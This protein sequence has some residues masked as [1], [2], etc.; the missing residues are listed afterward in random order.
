MSLMK[1][2]CTIAC[3]ELAKNSK[4][5][6]S[7]LHFSSQE[8]VLS[9]IQRFGRT[10][11]FFGHS[12]GRRTTF[13]SH[14]CFLAAFET[15]APLYPPSA[16][17]AFRRGNLSIISLKTYSASSLSWILAACI[18]IAKGRPRTSTQICTLRPLIFLFPSI[19]LS[20]STWLELLT[21][22]ESIMPRLGHSSLFAATL[23]VW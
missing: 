23:T 6:V 8:K 20:E 10:M 7:L 16:R 19:P 2:S 12:S 5:E 14:P 13:S 15:S 4:S 18:A 1:A 21:L 3:R 17:I 22:L 9:T 11:N